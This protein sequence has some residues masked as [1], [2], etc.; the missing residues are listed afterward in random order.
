VL[1]SVGI[2]L[3]YI[4]VPV[5]YLI[6]F[7]L[8]G[9]PVVWGAFGI[10][11]LG[12][13]IA[14]LLRLPV[15]LFLIKRN[16]GK[17]SRFIVY[18]SGPFEEGVRLVAL[19]LFII[20]R[21]GALSLGMGWAAIEVVFVAVNAIALRVLKDKTDDKALQA[22]KMLA[23]QGQSLD[24]SP[25]WGILER[26]TASAFHIGAA[27]IIAANPWLVLVMVPAHTYL[28]V[29]GV[30]LLKKSVIQTEAFI[31]IVGGMSLLIGLI[32]T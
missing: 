29:I 30:R 9:H 22:K 28:N 27:L 5:L 18:C 20:T 24:G 8:S 1:R 6:A 23:E 12:W 4:L 16:A 14:Y 31:A 19:L 32:I 13:W 3:L 11:A 2:V 17:P 15:Q 10:G 25:L 7:G 21:N 26:I